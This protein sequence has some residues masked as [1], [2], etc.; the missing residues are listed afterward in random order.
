VPNLQTGPPNTG[1]ATVFLNAGEDAIAD[2]TLQSVGSVTGTVFSTSNV[3]V[4]GLTVA[5]HTDSG[6]YRTVTDGAGNFDFA[7]VVTG[8]ARMEVFDPA[9][10]SGA[11]AT[12]TVIA[13]QNVNQNLTLRQG[14]GSLKG[15][16][17]DEFGNPVA[18]AQV[19]VAVAGDGNLTVT[20]LADGTY[21][22]NSVPI[23]PLFIGASDP[24]NNR[25]GNASGFMDLAGATITIDVTIS[26]RCCI[27]L[28]MPPRNGEPQP[29]PGWFVY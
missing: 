21:A 5:L 24:A 10:V 7:E 8:V 9:T 18:G 11:A 2:I 1:T 23:G 3:P 12:V 22:L 14:V 15:T 19:T 29:W 16:V 27:S 13:G 4:P 25:T 17:F 26:Q 28:L 6:D 20:T